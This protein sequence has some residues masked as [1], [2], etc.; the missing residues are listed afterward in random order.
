MD[1]LLAGGHEAVAKLCGVCHQALYL[2]IE[3]WIVERLTD[4]INLSRASGI[5][6]ESLPVR[7]RQM[8]QKAGRGRDTPSG[9]QGCGWVC[10]KRFR[11]SAQGTL[12]SRYPQIWGRRFRIGTRITRIP[13]FDRELNSNQV[14]HRK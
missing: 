4:G 9:S 8:G 13:I 7:N 5:P 6:I 14:R 3:Q 11:R 2:L 12:A 1:K 10:S